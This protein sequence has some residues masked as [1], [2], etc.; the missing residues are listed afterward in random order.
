MTLNG[1]TVAY[2]TDWTFDK[3]ADEIEVTAMGDSNKEYVAGL[4][5]GSGTIDCRFDGTDSGQTSGLNLV[6]EGTQVSLTLSDGVDSLTGSSVTILSSSI[7]ATYNDATTVTYGY[8]G[9]L[10]LSGV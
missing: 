10:V 5:E 4:A 7:S 8:R 6:T 3:Q 1:T 2:V 9:F